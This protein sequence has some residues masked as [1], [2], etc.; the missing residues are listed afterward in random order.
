L[1]F[2]DNEENQPVPGRN[3]TT[4]NA[5]INLFFVEAAFLAMTSFAVGAHAQLDPQGQAELIAPLLPLRPGVT[6]VGIFDE[7]L[8]HNALRSATLLDYTALRT[9]QVVDLR[10]KVHA[11]EVGR[12]E[13]RAP[14]QKSFVVTSEKGSGMIRHLALKPLI[15]SEIET[16]A[17]KEHHDSAISPANYTLEPLGEQP[18]GPYHCFVVR[19]IPKRRDKYLFEGKVWIDVEDYAVVRIEGHPAKKLSFWIE[20]ADFVRQY[21]KIGNFWLPQKDMTFV[22]VRLYGK[23]ALT[24]DHRDYSLNRSIDGT[25]SVEGTQSF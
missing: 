19:A 21:Q 2:E 17:G 3:T 15:A 6:E 9:Y 8:A 7:L 1:T 14:D 10:G 24:I 22:Q 23:K 16:A 12:M 13:Y 25:R 11:Q 20:R 4:P 5:K 18:V